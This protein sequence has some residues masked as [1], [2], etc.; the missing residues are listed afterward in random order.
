MPLKGT[1]VGA[2]VG[3]TVEK[4]TPDSIPKTSEGIHARA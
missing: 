1:N 2:I 3:K 4:L